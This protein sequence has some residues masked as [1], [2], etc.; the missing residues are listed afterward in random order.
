MSTASP[1]GLLPAGVERQRGGGADSEVA[2]D[3]ASGTGFLLT[4]L[5][6]LDTLLGEHG[7]VWKE[8]VQRLDTLRREIALTSLEDRR[9]RSRAARKPLRDHSA[10]PDARPSQPGLDEVRARQLTQEFEVALRETEERRVAL[11]AQMHDLRRRRQAV[12]QRLPAPLSRTY[13]SLADSGRLP[14]IAPVAKGA[15]GGCHAPL[16]E[17]VRQALSHGAVAVCARCERLL[18]PSEGGE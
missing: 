8:L 3:K 12:L 15:C 17:S 18:R 10:D 7:A 2:E 5:A 6:G 16:A 11:H 14:A 9:T 13:Q 1:E 4:Q